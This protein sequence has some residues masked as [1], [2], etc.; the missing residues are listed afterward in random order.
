MFRSSILPR[1]WKCR[2]ARSTGRWRHSPR[3]AMCGRTPRPRRTPSPFACRRWGFACSARAICPMPGNRCCSALPSKP[4]STAGWRSS[5]AA[6]S[7]GSRE[8]RVPRPACATSRRW[9][10]RSCSTPRLPARR[11]SRRCP[12]TRRCAS[13][14][15]ADSRCPAARTPGAFGKGVVRTI[16]ELRAH[17]KETRRRGYGLAIEEGEPGI[18]AMAAAFRASEDPRAPIAGTVSV[19]GPLIRLGPARRDEIS[20]LL[21][22]AAHDLAALWPLRQHQAGVPHVVSVRANA[23]RTPDREGCAPMS[24]VPASPSNA[25]SHCGSG[26]GSA[27]R[28]GTAVRHARSR[29]GDPLPDRDLFAPAPGVAIPGQE[30]RRAG[31][32]PSGA[33]ASSWPSSTSRAGSSSTMRS[34]PRTRSCSAFCWRRSSA[35]RSD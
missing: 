35:C 32:H 10:A 6:L 29:L 17:L 9:A 23:P 30:V 21:A 26:A 4:A 2:T 31:I 14:S 20:P 28:R 33:D 24:D 16:D 19:A 25:T 15:L 13:S 22:S 27:R 5:T 3:A 1:A 8:R 12:K 7:P 18:V 11:G 34:S